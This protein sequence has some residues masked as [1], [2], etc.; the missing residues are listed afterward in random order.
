MPNTIT[1]QEMKLQTLRRIL[2][3]S[4]IGFAIPSI[5]FLL[6]IY[7]MRD[8]EYNELP[9]AYLIY[10]HS[11]DEYDA[12]T[13]LVGSLKHWRKLLAATWFME[14]NPLKGFEGLK[15]PRVEK[16]WVPPDGCH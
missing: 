13:K 11:I 16:E 9:S 6:P 3:I 5:I 14:G 2:W 15:G 12:A 8:T 1:P 7:S 4:F 10:M